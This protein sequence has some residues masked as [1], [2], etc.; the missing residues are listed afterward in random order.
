MEPI[1]PESPSAR[2]RSD[3]S[4]ASPKSQRRPDAT[5]HD[6]PLYCCCPVGSVTRDRAGRIFRVV[7]GKIAERWDVMQLTQSGG[8]KISERRRLN[9]GRS[10]GAVR[11][12]L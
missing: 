8:V 10:P 5:S 6:D 11:D 9:T 7:D 1:G 12:T 4:L 2:L 3:V